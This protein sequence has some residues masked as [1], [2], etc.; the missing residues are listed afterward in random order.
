MYKTVVKM[1]SRFCLKLSINLSLIF[2]DFGINCLQIDK[3]KDA[4]KEAVS[5]KV[6]RER[7]CWQKYSFSFQTKSKITELKLN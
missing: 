3:K 1:T 5:T 6:D 7:Q 2:I 4:N